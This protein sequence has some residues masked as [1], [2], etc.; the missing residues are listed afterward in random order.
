[1]REYPVLI[2][3]CEEVWKYLSDP[4]PSWSFR[5]KEEV[6]QRENG[7]ISMVHKILKP[8]NWH[9]TY[10]EYDRVVVENQVRSCNWTFY[11]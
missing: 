3:N 4:F 10:D 8:T 5:D 9:L 7:R 6:V 11:Y 1:M 2:R